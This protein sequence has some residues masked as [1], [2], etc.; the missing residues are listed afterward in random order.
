[1]LARTIIKLSD[2]T[3]GYAGWTS[4]TARLDFL[5]RL[6]YLRKV[7]A[8]KNCGKKC[9]G[10][11]SANAAPLNSP[12]LWEAVNEPPRGIFNVTLV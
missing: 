6:G 3:N 11:P 1:V 7:C 4:L 2:Q 12:V 9:A 8:V 5:H 10:C